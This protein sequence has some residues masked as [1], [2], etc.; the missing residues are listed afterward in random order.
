MNCSVGLTYVLRLLQFVTKCIATDKVANGAGGKLEL[1]DAY[2][3]CCRLTLPRQCYY[4]LL[5]HISP[6]CIAESASKDS[7]SKE[8]VLPAG[9]KAVEEARRGSNYG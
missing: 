5:R 8:F 6:L 3:A 9:Y 4:L 1:K 2:R 7:V